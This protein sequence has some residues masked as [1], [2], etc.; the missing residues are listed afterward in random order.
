M[1]LIKRVK[2]RQKE[3]KLQGRESILLREE[4]FV[5]V[6]DGVDFQVY[7]LIWKKELVNRKVKVE[8]YKLSVVGDEQ[9]CMAV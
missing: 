3:L 9:M 4:P 1:G 8:R 7:L 6:K 5:S 2:K